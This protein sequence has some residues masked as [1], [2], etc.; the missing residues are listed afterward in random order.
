[1]TRAYKQIPGAGRVP[2]LG[3]TTCGTESLGMLLP[4]CELSMTGGLFQRPAE[5]ASLQATHQ[6]AS[7]ELNA[8]GL[9][10]IQS[11]TRLVKAG[12]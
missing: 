7:V 1:M 11:E 12:R 3:M 5:P 8:D 2:A 4:L 10:M 6:L 9:V